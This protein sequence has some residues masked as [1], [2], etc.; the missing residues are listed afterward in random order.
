VSFDEKRRYI[1]ALRSTEINIMSNTMKKEVVSH[2]DK[3]KIN[4]M[5]Y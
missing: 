2:N 4:P 1:I 5:Q 3:L